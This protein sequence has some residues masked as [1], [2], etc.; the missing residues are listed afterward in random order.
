MNRNALALGLLLFAAGSLGCLRSDSAPEGEG[1]ADATSY[2][3]GPHR[4]RLLAAG[5]FALELTIFEDGVPPAR[6]P[7]VS[8][9]PRCIVSGGSRSSAGRAAGA[10]VTTEVG[11]GVILG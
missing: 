8:S 1:H 10:P 4:G 5:D 2:E 11:A 9:S 3:R 6:T 7:R